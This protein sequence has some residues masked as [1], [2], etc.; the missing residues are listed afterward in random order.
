MVLRCG[1][2]I[3]AVLGALACGSVTGPS[4]GSSDFP[5]SFATCGS[6]VL[7]G[8]PS[9]AEGARYMILGLS[10]KV[11]D[12]SAMPSVEARLRVGD[13]VELALDWSPPP[14]ARSSCGSAIALEWSI[15]GHDAATLE[16][17]PYH[18]VARLRAR[19]PGSFTVFVDFTGPDAVRHRTT[20][21][22]CLASR[23]A[24]FEC[25][26]IKKIAVVRVVT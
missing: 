16:A 19:A 15:V 2:A 9:T 7:A 24:G 26:D 13:V 21:A 5:V 4:T 6:P 18:L 14:G 17:E 10:A 23:E 8:P 22:C 12:P 1:L 3:T 25:R 11:T 20:L